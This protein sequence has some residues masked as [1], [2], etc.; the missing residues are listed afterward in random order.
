MVGLHIAVATPDHPEFVWATFE[1]NVNVPDCNKSGQAQSGWSF[2]SPACAAEIA[3]NNDSGNCDFNKPK[4]ETAFTQELGT[5]IC[6]DYAY[7]SDSSDH[8][9][10]ENYD[11]VTTLN[12]NVQPNLTGNFSVLKNYF[13]VGAIWLSD[14][15]P[16]S[17]AVVPPSTYS[18]SNQRGSLR[19]ANSVAETSYQHINPNVTSGFVSNC[20][21]CHSYN[22]TDDPTSSKNTTLSNGLSHIFAEITQQTG[23]CYDTQTTK[24]INSNSQSDKGEICK[25][26]CTQN[27]SPLVWNGE[28]TNQDVTTGAQLPMTVCGCCSTLK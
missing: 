22:G 23:Q 24:I 25:K 18:T 13:N 15:G 17:D 20:M 6:R 21:G 26:A 28:W 1:H 27:N 12:K 2:T 5:E 4:P 19:L 3:G 7:G 14:I 11:A 10:T 9:Y 16:S 8:K